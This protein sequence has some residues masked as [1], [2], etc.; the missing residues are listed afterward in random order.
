M[1][2]E[3]T[4]RTMSGGSIRIRI[5]RGAATEAQAD[6][7]VIFAKLFDGLGEGGRLQPGAFGVGAPC[8]AAH[9][10]QDAQR[11]DGDGTIMPGRLA[12]TGATR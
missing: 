8:A 9:G 1:A 3:R 4:L 11:A 6:G 7:E 12:N 10:E 2:V 5:R